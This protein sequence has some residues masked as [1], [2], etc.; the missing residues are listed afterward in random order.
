M[1]TPAKEA[2]TESGPVQTSFRPSIVACNICGRDVAVGARGPVPMG[3]RDCLA[4]MDDLARLRRD[5]AKVCESMAGD[6]SL[7]LPLYRLLKREIWIWLET[8]F[9]SDKRDPKT[10]RLI[11]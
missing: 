3:H 11:A 10:G 2:A 7:R 8:E 1:K 9:S 5:V 6:R 4:I